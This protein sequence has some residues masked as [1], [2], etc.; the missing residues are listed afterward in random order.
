MLKIYQLRLKQNSFDVT[1]KYKGVNVRVAFVDG[2]TYNG[3][4]AK[5]YTNNPFKQRAIEN[6]QMFKNKEIVLEREVEEE[7]DRNKK[8][9]EKPM[10]KPQGARKT[11]GTGTTAKAAGKKSP[12][13]KANGSGKGASDGE[14]AAEVHETTGAVAD[15]G[16]GQGKMSFDNL[17]DAI[18]YI[19]TNYQEQ[20]QTANE[21]RAFLKEKGIKAT[22]KNG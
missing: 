16:D 4:P 21:A 2:N 19:A 15:G 12:A 1:L 18:L 20:V 22:I 5:C 14:N 8:A 3:T 9:V 7:S 6:S 17:A 13:T 11:T 10:A